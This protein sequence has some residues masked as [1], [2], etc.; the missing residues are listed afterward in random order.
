LQASEYTETLT[1]AEKHM[2][3][4][5]DQFNILEKAGDGGDYSSI[6]DTYLEPLRLNWSVPDYSR[7]EKPPKPPVP[8]V[9][10]QFYYTR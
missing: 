9:I 6:T 1:E 8:E 4:A 10:V 7:L 5:V 3:T 2:T